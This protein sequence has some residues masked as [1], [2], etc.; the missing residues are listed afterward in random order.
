VAEKLTEFIK[1]STRESLISRK[2]T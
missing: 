2:T 1:K